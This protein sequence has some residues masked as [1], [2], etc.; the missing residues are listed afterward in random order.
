MGLCGTRVECKEGQAG[1]GYI[2]L[3]VR[4]S[5]AEDRYDHKHHDQKDCEP[6]E[7]EFNAS[8]DAES[9]LGSAERSRALSTY[10]QQDHSDERYRYDAHCCVQK[11]FH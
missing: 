8:S 2:R 4:E 7:K 11:R 1:R 10:L 9:A 3:Y 5:G 6:E